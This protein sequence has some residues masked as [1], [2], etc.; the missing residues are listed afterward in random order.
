MKNY[1]NF[2][3]D[4]TGFRRS[5]LDDL[6]RDL[7][8]LALR[9]R[10]RWI[11]SR[12]KRLGKL[13]N[14][15]NICLHFGSGPRII[16]GWINIDAY[17]YPGLDAELDLRY[18]LPLAQGSCRRIFAEHVLEH[19]N[20]IDSIKICKEFYRLVQPEGVCRLIVPDIEKYW[21]AYQTRDFE[22]FRIVDADC[23]IPLE[24]VNNIYYGHFH[25]WM[26]D[27][28]LLKDFLTQAGFSKIIR[29]AYRSSEYVDL[30][31]ERDDPFRKESSL[32]IDVLK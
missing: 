1:K 19:F 14:L 12:R 15:S 27:F 13:C 24:G 22:W 28:E 18:Q 31:L 8:L 20:P 5:T 6:T 16:H 30:R 32:Y 21:R 26:Y 7:R 2:I 29:S 9:C 11:P 25:R 10:N 3:M 23:R 17:P 4:L